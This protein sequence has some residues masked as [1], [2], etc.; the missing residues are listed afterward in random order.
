MDEKIKKIIL[1]F[2]RGSPF[3]IVEPDPENNYKKSVLFDP[4]EAFSPYISEE[5]ISPCPDDNVVV[6]RLKSHEILCDLG[7]Y[8]EKDIIQEITTVYSNLLETDAIKQKT[9]I[10][11]LSAQ[12]KILDV[13]TNFE[14]ARLMAPGT[15][16]GKYQAN[17][18]RV[19]EKIE[20]PKN[21]IRTHMQVRYADNSMPLIC[22]PGK[23]QKHVTIFSFINSLVIAQPSI[24]KIKA[25]KVK[26]IFRYGIQYD[27]QY[28]IFQI[29]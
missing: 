9:T 8:T 12:T 1:G 16:I 5:E 14:E 13:G 15:W 19:K 11:L 21:Q 3:K 6:G 24:E 27:D 25:N 23:I 10:Q 2:I 4:N 29:T 18:G 20:L 7:R 26:I 17:G 22:V 28:E